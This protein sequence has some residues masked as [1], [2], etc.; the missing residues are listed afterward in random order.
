MATRAQEEEKRRKEEA[1]VAARREAYYALPNAYD[2]GNPV[3]FKNQRPTGNRP[4]LWRG[5]G[6]PKGGGQPS[7]VTAYGGMVPIDSQTQGISEA[8]MNADW[9]AST[10]PG[11]QPQGPPPPIP[12]T[13]R[14]VL[15][16][17]NG[18]PQ[19]YMDVPDTGGTATNAKP[20][21][22]YVQQESPAAARAR[23]RREQQN[24]PRPVAVSTDAARAAQIQANEQAK[25]DYAARLAAQQAQQAVAARQQALS[26]EYQ[27][28]QDEAKAE[29]ERR[30]Q[31]ILQGY[32][33]VTSDSAGRWADTMAGL[34]KRYEARLKETQ[35]LLKNAGASEA[36]DIRQGWAN[37]ESQGMSDLVSRG[38]TGTTIRPTM[39][40]GY[41]REM[42]ADLGR[43]RDRLRDQQANVYGT[44]TGQQIGTAQQVGMT[45]ASAA[46][47]WA[48]NRLGFM[49]N[50]TDS[51]PDYNQLAA[52]EN[53]LGAAAAY[54]QYAGPTPAQPPV[55]ANAARP[56]AAPGI[57]PPSVPRPANP[58][59][60]APGFGLVG[61]VSS[62]KGI[63]M[64]KPGPAPAPENL[65]FGASIPMNERPVLDPQPGDYPRWSPSAANGQPANQ[66]GYQPG[67]S[68]EMMQER[69]NLWA[70]Q[71]PYEATQGMTG[72]G[73]MFPSVGA[74]RGDRPASPPRP[75]QTFQPVRFDANGNQI[76]PRFAGT[77]QQQKIGLDGQP[78]VEEPIVN[79]RPVRPAPGI[80]PVLPSPGEQWPPQPKPGVNP[81]LRRQPNL[82]AGR[83]GR[84]NSYR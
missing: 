21:Q 50:R 44:M 39:Q 40:M 36:A 63:M 23:L 18:V 78:L 65:P 60:P 80:N 74:N 20:R 11:W 38:L 68:P 16:T 26:D 64:S 1:A 25:A 57:R 72:Q 59:A 54:E 34:D 8:Q 30:Y 47:Q 61:G 48:A 28:A 66:Y 69:Y 70:A 14:V 42:N 32:T 53:G 62:T 67:D 7:R 24:A 81:V 13:R 33:D 3:P 17:F 58:S 35:K 43:L 12:G 51:Y 19:T 27:R 41:Q 76:L 75:G 22:Q 4:P 56:V 77:P 6:G 31:D 45:G 2:T 52:L 10:R 71:N 37:R 79:K 83:P 5:G 9:N 73:L 46:D 15:S 49:E 55:Q 82:G 84:L 29:N